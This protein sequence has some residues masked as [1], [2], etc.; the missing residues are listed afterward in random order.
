MSLESCGACGYALSIADQRC[1]HCASPAVT[2]AGRLKL[3]PPVLAVISGG[4]LLCAVLVYRA[5][6]G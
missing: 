2:G 4:A 3:S 5:F 1:R 6:L